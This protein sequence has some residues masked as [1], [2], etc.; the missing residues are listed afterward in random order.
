MCSVL[1]L[2]SNGGWAGKSTAPYWQAASLW[3]LT[4][5]LSFLCTILAWQRKWGPLRQELQDIWPI[6]HF[7]S[8][9]L[10]GFS[11]LSSNVKCQCHVGH[12]VYK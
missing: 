12:F 6:Y 9:V 1:L 4:R 8:L 7:I 11:R 3:L 10:H 5:V 2:H